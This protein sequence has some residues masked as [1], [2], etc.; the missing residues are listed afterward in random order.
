MLSELPLMLLCRVQVIVAQAVMGRKEDEDHTKASDLLAQA[1]IQCP[2]NQGMFTALD[3]GGANIIRYSINHPLGLL[4]LD[5]SELGTGEDRRSGGVDYLTSSRFSCRP[6]LLRATTSIN[7]D[8]S[9]AFLRSISPSD[10]V[11]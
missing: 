11:R 9:S 7:D 4:C 1:L 6:L 3:V 5:T 8:V 10:D 2:A